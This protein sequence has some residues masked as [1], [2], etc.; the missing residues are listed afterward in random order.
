MSTPA[1]QPATQYLPGALVT[2][3]SNNIVVVE[4]PYNNSFESGL[5]NW[6]ITGK[7]CTNSQA[8]AACSASSGEVYD[9]TESVLIGPQAGDGTGPT[10]YNPGPGG[11]PACLVILTNSFQAAVTPGKII[12]FSARFYNLIGNITTHFQFGGA[13][14]A[15]Y[16]ASHGF[17]G[18]SPAQHRYNP[19]FTAGAEPDAACDWGLRNAWYTVGGH[20]VAPAGAAY[21]SAVI[22]VSTTAASDVPMYADYFV[23]DYSIQGYPTGLVFQATQTGPGTSAANEPTWPVTPGQTVQD[24]SVTWTAGYDSQ[25]TWAAQSILTSG[26]TEPAWPT[27]IGG[28]IADNNIEWTAT[29]GLI[30]DPNCPHTSTA[31]AIAAAK[32]FAADNDIIRFT[33]TSTATD[34]TSSQ[35]AGF[36]PFGLQTYGNEP[37]AGLGLYRSNLVAFNAQGYQMWQV[38][39][40]PNNIAILDAEPV[41]CIYEK[42]IQPVN[43]DLV[44]LSPVGI[45]NIGTAGAAGNLQAGQFGKQVDPIVKAL[46]KYAAANGIEVKSLFYPGT[47]QYWLLFGA[48]AIVLTVNGN[49]VMSWSRYTF[50]SAITDH[51]T[52]DGVLY[53]RTG[54]LVWQI[55]EDTL[56]DDV[57]GT[58][59]GFDG[60][61]SWNYIECGNLGVDKIMEGFDITVGEIDDD[62]EI[63]NNNVQVAVSIGYNQSDR[64]MAT[65]PFTVT[66]DSIPGTMIP[67][68][69][70]A[71]SFQF[72][73]DF[74]S[75]QDW[76]WA[77]L[78]IYAKELRKP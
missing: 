30:T 52:Q 46:I 10:S 41:G 20:G 17:I 53:L 43:N 76:G 32:V 58:N 75:G 25:V 14:I 54:D 38:D 4:Q 5:T 50:P 61:M 70:V 2:P 37:C 65:E 63:T 3:R 64:E 13:A 1:W 66:G 56:L 31:V 7:Y 22:I 15:W 35:D 48:E 77:A 26:A 71:P 49:N 55:D 62:G 6:A 12:N 33:A 42:S 51:T 74:G 18:Y 72:R 16:N 36:I 11:D 27:L 40:D 29:D 23:W 44:F 28:A 45:R 68:P 78:N 73:L 9:G 67:M 47:G 24:G 21:A 8:Q 60:A 34:W 57:G 19:N 59:A 39:P 69:L